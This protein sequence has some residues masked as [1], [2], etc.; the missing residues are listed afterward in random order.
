VKKDARGD[1]DRLISGKLRAKAGRGGAANA[2]IEVDGTEYAWAQRHGW[3]VAAKG[4]KVLSLSVS[5][6]PA[7]TRELILDLGLRISPEEGP[8]SEERVRR[9]LEEGIREA[10]DAGWDP[11]SRGRAFRYEIMDA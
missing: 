4:L 2:V 6:R 9:A 10:L 3:T 11:E 5:L 7:R 8:P 1:G